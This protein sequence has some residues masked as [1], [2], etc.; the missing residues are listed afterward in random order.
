MS[1]VQRSSE[2][3]QSSQKSREANL[4]Q[5]GWRRVWARTAELNQPG[6]VHK[7]IKRKSLFSSKSLRLKHSRPRLAGDSWKLEH[8]GSKHVED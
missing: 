4:N 3:E 6:R 5:S 8:L 7:E 1:S 2:A